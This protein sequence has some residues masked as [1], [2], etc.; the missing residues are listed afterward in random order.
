MDFRAGRKLSS[1]DL[2]LILL[3]LLAQRPRHGYD[4]IKAIEEHSNGFYAPSPGV[5]YP[6]LTYLEEAGETQSV[7][8]GTR[9]LYQLTDAGRARLEQARTDVDAMLEQL[10][11][12]GRGMDRVRDAFA[13]KHEGVDF[14]SLRET[15]S[16]V[17]E[18]FHAMQQLRSALA[19]QHAASRKR[20]LEIAAILQR[21]A[22]AIRAAKG[23]DE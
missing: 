8:E 17:P 15:W 7:A 10:K 14:A 3:A 11:E 18:L 21:A 9:K 19:E 6:A 2:Q 13:G 1:S 23:G 12:L 22:E 16:K 5:I 4:L 20:L